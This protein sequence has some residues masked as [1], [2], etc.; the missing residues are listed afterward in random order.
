MSLLIR[1]EEDGDRLSQVEL[2]CADDRTADRGL[3]NHDRADR[4]GVRALALH[5]DECAKLRARPEL[6][7]SAVEECLRWDGP[8]S[9][10][11]RV[12]HEDCEFG[13]KTIPVEH[14]GAGDPR[15]R[16]PRPR[17]VPRSRP[18]RHRAL[19]QRAPR[20]RWRRSLSVSALTS[21]AWKARSRSV[22]SCADSSGSSWSPSTS[23]GAARSSASP[24][25]SE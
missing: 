20:F 5:P 18:F 13:G 10:A 1:A 17:S 24:P 2:V 12:L 25:L 21:R 9:A 23:S 4:N 3:R 7:A 14:A 19:A 15:R 22:R 8:I 6:I 16:Q 11:V